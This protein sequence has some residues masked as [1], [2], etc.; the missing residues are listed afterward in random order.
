MLLHDFMQEFDQHRYGYWL[1]CKAFQIKE[2]NMMIPYTLQLP[3]FDDW[4]AG[5]EAGGG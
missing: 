5:F 1:A 2:L 3:H 4:A